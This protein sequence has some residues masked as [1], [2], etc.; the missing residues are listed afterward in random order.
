MSETERRLA[1]L[2]EG[3]VRAAQNA[4][5][6]WYREHLADDFLISTVDGSL[7][8]KTEFLRRIGRG[9][10]GSSFAAVDA[11]IRILGEMALIH[12]GFSYTKP[13]GDAG[14]GRYTDIW[15]LRQGRWLC[16][17]AHFNRF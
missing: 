16:V 9:P 2:N 17:S 12:A 5:V 6:E 14:R 4:D 7:S 10:F 1:E 3:Y 15:M 11:R 13:D 8:D